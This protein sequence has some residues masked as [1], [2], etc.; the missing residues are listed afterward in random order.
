[1]AEWDDGYVSDVPYTS[2]F[3]RESA[4]VGIATAAAL[5]GFGCPDLTRPFRFAD[6]GCG[7]GV[8]ALVVAATMPQSEVWGFDFNPAH[9]AAARD[10]ARRAGLS[11]IHFE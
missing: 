7:N 6:L 4:P 8:T 3:H 9:I 2:G 11:N 1:M 5:T 10:V